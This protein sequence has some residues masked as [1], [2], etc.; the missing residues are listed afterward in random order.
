MNILI[1][2][3]SKLIYSEFSKIEAENGTVRFYQIGNDNPVESIKF[4]QHNGNTAEMEARLAVLYLIE[5]IEDG[6]KVVGL[7]DDYRFEIKD[8]K[9][10]R[11]DNSTPI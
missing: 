3:G 8:N 2:S 5:Q 9:V 10:V 1:K 6:T 11:I 7:R 4:E